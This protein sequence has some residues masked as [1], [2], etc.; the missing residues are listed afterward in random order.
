MPKDRKASVQVDDSSACPIVMYIDFVQYRFMHEPE[1]DRFIT[2]SWTMNFI[3][4]KKLPFN[5]YMLF[6]VDSFHQF[7]DDEAEDNVHQKWK[8]IFHDYILIVFLLKPRTIRW[9]PRVH[10]SIHPI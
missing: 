5:M 4:T 10:F 1:F 6:K 7:A 2:H 3:F 9:Y 8:L